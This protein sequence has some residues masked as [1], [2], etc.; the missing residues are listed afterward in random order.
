MKIHDPLLEFEVKLKLV[1]GIPPISFTLKT[2]M[3]STMCLKK[4]RV[5]VVFS[6][7]VS[8]TI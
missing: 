1:F 8:K 3:V 7:N 4:G 5:T 2:L 6:P